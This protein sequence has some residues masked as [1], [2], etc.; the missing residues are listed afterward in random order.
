V[1]NVL[2]AS[3][4]KPKPEND[5]HTDAHNEHAEDEHDDDHCGGD[6]DD[7]DEEEGNED[8]DDED[9]HDGDDDGNGNDEDEDDETV[10]AVHPI[11]T[12]V[13]ATV[14]TRKRKRTKRNLHQRKTRWRSKGRRRRRVDDQSLH[15]QSLLEE[16]RTVMDQ[17]DSIVSA[18]PWSA[19][20][21]SPPCC[22]V[23]SVLTRVACRS[24]RDDKNDSSSRV[25]G[26]KTLSVWL[27]TRLMVLDRMGKVQAQMRAAHLIGVAYVSVR[28]WYADFVARGYSFSSSLRGHHPKTRWL[29]D[30]QHVQQ[31]AKQWVMENAR[32]RG[33][34]NLTVHAFMHYLND[35]LLPTL[36]DQP[37]SPGTICACFAH[38]RFVARV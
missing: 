23:R 17:L 33:Q 24:R 20:L 16:A 25:V 3:E 26:K 29:L 37:I 21:P 7:N 8:E 27:M 13:T 22:C 5:T 10:S 38:A 4:P 2:A 35:T 11:S 6:D 32:Q 34:P 19:P 14:V 36:P 28:R 15:R 31:Q 12:P 1:Q 30:D 18:L 9:D